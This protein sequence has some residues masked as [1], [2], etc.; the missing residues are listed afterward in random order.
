MLVHMWTAMFMR[1]GWDSVEAIR[2]ALPISRSARETVGADRVR[3]SQ[4][5]RSGRVVLL[6]NCV[7]YRGS[8]GEP[9]CV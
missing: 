1:L 5:S 2:L 8:K 6:R 9:L 7:M 3:K 4:N